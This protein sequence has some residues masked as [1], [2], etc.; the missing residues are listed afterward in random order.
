MMLFPKPS[1]STP[2]K[3]RPTYDLSTDSPII[4]P[5][6]TGA[7]ENTSFSSPPVPALQRKLLRMSMQGREPS[8]LRS[9]LYFDDFEKESTRSG[10]D[11]VEYLTEDQSSGGVA[12]WEDLGPD[13]LETVVFNK[14]SRNPPPTFNPDLSFG[15]VSMIEGIYDDAARAGA[16]LDSQQTGT[17]DVTFGAAPEVVGEHN[18]LEEPAVQASQTGCAALINEAAG[19]KTIEIPYT[20][21][22][23]SIQTDRALDVS[24]YAIQSTSAMMDAAVETGSETIVTCDAGVQVN[25]S[26]ESRFYSADQC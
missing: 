18:N 11:S 23:A 25:Q 19:I 1:P 4:C 5:S 8:R 22:D 26:G 12:S 9:E 2:A 17:S 14:K 21:I 15:D 24:W 16:Y 6:L 20:M 7:E 13:S 3:S 10:D